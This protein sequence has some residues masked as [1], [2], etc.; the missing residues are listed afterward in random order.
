VVTFPP[1][2]PAA[3]TPA[4]GDVAGLVD[5]G[6]GRR[7]F[8]QCRGEGEPTVVLVSG[9]DNTGGAWSVLPEGVAAPA[10]L[11]G[12]AAF[13]RVCA[14]DRPGTVLDALPPDDRSRSDPVPQPT[15]AEDAVADLHA[16][17]HAADV[18]GPYVLAGHSLGGL[19]VRLYAATYPDEVAGLVLVDA[20]SEGIPANLTPEQWQT[21]IATNGVPPPELLAAYPEYERIAVDAAA[22]AIERAVATHPLRPMPLAVVSAGRTGEMTPDEAAT[23]PPGYAD[24]LLAANRANQAYLATLLPDAFWV[25]ANDSGHYV[26]AE[27]PALVLAAVRRVV[28]AVRDPDTWTMQ[29]ATP[30]P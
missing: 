16:L 27:Q 13:T 9:Y 5:I 20:F 30:G 18:P 7:M 22:V 4:A 23:F 17:L 11:P 10:V 6:G 12:V 1:L 15:T 24:A 25:T 3:A 28:A 21:W 14:Y 26:Q 2:A 19:L 8:L 29:Q